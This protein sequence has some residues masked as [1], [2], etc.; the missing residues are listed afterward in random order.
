MWT[1][2]LTLQLLKYKYSSLR[3]LFSFN[4]LCFSLTSMVDWE[5]K[6]KCGHGW[7]PRQVPAAQAFRCLAILD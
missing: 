3:M 6:E 7:I 5:K 2:S 4:P 1:F